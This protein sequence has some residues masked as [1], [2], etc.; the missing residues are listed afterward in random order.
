MRVLLA[1]PRGFCAGVDRAIAIVEQALGDYGAALDWYERAYQ[2]RD[3]LMTVFHTDPTFRIVAPNR[4]TSI[5]DEP[6]WINLVRRVGLS[7]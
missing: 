5:T 4:S 7:P 2:S 3:F 1:N 6:R